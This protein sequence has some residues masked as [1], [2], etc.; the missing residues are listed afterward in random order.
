MVRPTTQRRSMSA[1]GCSEGARPPTRFQR[2]AEGVDR[3]SSKGADRQ[4]SKGGG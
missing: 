3:Q 2:R 4:R 1:H